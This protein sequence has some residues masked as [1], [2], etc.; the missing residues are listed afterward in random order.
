M[1][2]VFDVLMLVIGWVW[3]VMG[4]VWLVMWF[5]MR[6]VIDLLFLSPGNLSS[7]FTTWR[8]M[9]SPPG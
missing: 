4:W 6:V 7:L 5:V 2:V 8:P 9:P 1:G 3:L